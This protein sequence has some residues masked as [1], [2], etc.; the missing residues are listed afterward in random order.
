M[1]DL[2]EIPFDS[3]PDSG[4]VPA[5]EYVVT[6][7][8]DTVETRDGNQKLA[9][10]FRIDEGPYIGRVLFLDF[11]LRHANEKA[12]N[13]S[14]SALKSLFKSLGLETLPSDSSDGHGMQAKITVRLYNEKYHNLVSS[15]QLVADDDNPFG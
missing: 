3:I 4:T 8:A 7:I 15:R 13:A 2:S 6:Y 10:R 12:R 1:A 9:C 11:W 14:L 5:G